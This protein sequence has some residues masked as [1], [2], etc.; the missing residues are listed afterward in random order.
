MSAA[1]AEGLEA[2]LVWPDEPG[3]HPLALISHGSPRSA[4]ER[5]QMTALAMLPQA[6]ELARRG[7]AAAVV[8]RRGYG[9][10]PGGWAEDFGR[11]SNAHYQEASAPAVADLKAAVAYLATLPEVDASRII[12]LGVSA[13]GFATVAL[14]ADPPPGLVAAVSFAGGRGSL[15][16]DANCSPDALVSAFRSFGSRSRVPMLWVYAEND[17]FFGPGI[18][19]R[20]VEAFKEGGGQ[21]TFIAP[22]PF[23]SDG[24]K[25]FSSAGIPIWTP[26]VDEFLRSRGLVLRST[27]LALP[28]PPGI[29]LPAELSADGRGAFASYLTSPPHKAFAVSPT[30]AYGWRSGR[31]TAED[32]RSEALALCGSHGKGCQVIIV[33]DAK[34]D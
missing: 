14:T 12:A 32:A 11:C 5:P 3:R 28:S 7:W 27:Q 31:R 19:H 20:F 34:A 1:G 4:A 25:L 30:G 24:H 10:S 16:S 29:D 22:P 15:S 13:G 2:L 17:H 8:M 9:S 6:K 23:G 21:V 18:A 33:D 26:L